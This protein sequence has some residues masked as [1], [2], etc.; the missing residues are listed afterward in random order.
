MINRIYNFILKET[1]QPSI[2]SLFFNPYFFCRNDLYKSIIKLKINHK[3]KSILDLGCGKKPYEN[4]FT[5]ANSYIGL[6]IKPE[7]I[8]RNNRADIF[9]DGTN[10]PFSNQQFDI[11]ICN[12]TLEHVE[13]VNSFFSEIKRVLKKNGLILITVPFIWSEHEIPN[14]FRRFTSFGIK[15]FFEKNNFKILKFNKSCVGIV[16]V[17]QIIQD[18]LF[19]KI[20]TKNYFLNCLL[21]FFTFSFFQIIIFFLSKILCSK[22]QDSEFY[23]DNIVL[24]EKNE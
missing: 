24:G 17:Y 20:S 7:N 21:F 19:K 15:S 3:G 4:L 8:I 11:V 14:D 2:V 12:Q 5:K 10:F 23:I 9:Y 6:D 16:A 22:E 13:N 1:H 18:F